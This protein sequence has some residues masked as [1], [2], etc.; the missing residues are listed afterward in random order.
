MAPVPV[1]TDR[2][3][4]PLSGSVAAALRHGD[5]RSPRRL[6][7]RRVALAGVAG[8][9]VIFALL[10][11]RAAIGAARLLEHVRL[12]WLGVGVAAEAASLLSFGRL[13]RVLLC[14]AQATVR[15]RDAVVAVTL[16]GTALARVLPG[17]AASAGV[18]AY[19]QLRRRG[20]E[21]STALW[22]L[23]VA[24][25]LSS[26]GLFVII[27]VGVELGGSRGPPASLRWVAAALASVPVVIGAAGVALWH[28]PPVRVRAQHLARHIEGGSPACRRC[29]LVVRGLWVKVCL[30]RLRPARWLAAWLWGIANWVFD[31]ALLVTC[32]VAL[33]GMVPWRGVVFAYGLSQIATSVP[34]TPAGFGVAEASLAGLLVAD[35]VPGARALAI[36]L[37]Y[38][39]VSL[40]VVGAL[41]TGAGLR[42]HSTHAF[43][44][45]H[46][47]ARPIGL[48]AQNRRA[49][50]VPATDEQGRTLAHSS[51]AARRGCVQ[52]SDRVLGDG[53]D[54]IDLTSRGEA[55]AAQ[56]DCATRAVRRQAHR[57]EDVRGF[58]MRTMAGRTRRDR[59]ASS[60]EDVDDRVP[61]EPL[62]RHVH[63]LRQAVFSGA[64]DHRAGYR[65]QPLSQGGTDRSSP[66]LL[67]R[68]P[69]PGARRI[70]SCSQADDPEQ[71]LRA[72]PAVVLLLASEDELLQR[73]L[74]ADLQG[75]DALW[76][77]ELV[78]RDRHEPLRHSDVLLARS[79]DGV[80]VERDARLT[81]DPRQRVDGLECAGLVVGVHDRD[82][83]GI[84][85][86]RPLQCFR[87]DAPGAV[88]RQHRQLEAELAQ[89][90]A[91]SQDGW[92]LDRGGDDVA[93]IG[94]VAKARADDDARRPFRTAGVEH[95]LLGTAPEKSGN[96]G[97]RLV[98]ERGSGL[99]VEVG[100]RGVPEGRHGL[101]HGITDRRQ[102]RGRGVVVEVET[103][104]DHRGAVDRWVGH[105][106]CP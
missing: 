62:E 57:E 94:K 20:T 84:P 101:V 38:R 27:V 15:H 100:A 88:D 40:L 87:I 42:L 68:V 97:P 70:G 96:R 33:G 51:V 52:L 34:L 12:G 81:S 73:R 45:P 91:G 77:M 5:A 36:V 32:M 58:G 21:R 22:V 75:S 18:W 9:M 85:P 61:A 6:L 1:D 64:V 55:T 69:E 17:G 80:A 66:G 59:D 29:G 46:R 99:P 76:S 2:E 63:R 41:G 24:G 90:L 26:L 105:V 74:G 43:D 60:G 56:P 11:A 7:L 44:A 47:L 35:G 37:L 8:A 16:A 14:A 13:R 30:A 95:D 53:H 92:V 104:A 82:E 4:V 65:R 102:K 67:V 48:R 39:G 93:G 49:R 54:L 23:L 106:R 89:E 28:C 31:G 10:D 3:Q 78:G 98:E 25:A 50:S 71:V 19:R 83:S 79:L 72:S 86:K 103:A